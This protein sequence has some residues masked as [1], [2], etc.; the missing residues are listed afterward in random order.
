MVK[1]ILHDRGASCKSAKDE[2]NGCELTTHLQQSTKHVGWYAEFL[3][4][5]NNMSSKLPRNDVSIQIHFYP[6]VFWVT[7]TAQQGTCWWQMSPRFS[8]PFGVCVWWWGWRNHWAKKSDLKSMICRWAAKIIHKRISASSAIYETCVLG[9]PFLQNWKL[10]NKC[11]TLI[12]SKT[13]SFLT[14]YVFPRH[15]LGPTWIHLEMFIRNK[16]WG[17]IKCRPS[18]TPLGW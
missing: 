16:L 11:Y 3:I 7:K 5:K 2:G 14:Q 6:S 18:S 10:E 13:Q 8:S 1:F 9:S 12:V 4:T 17:R 15:S